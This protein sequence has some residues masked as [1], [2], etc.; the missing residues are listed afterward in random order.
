VEIKMTKIDIKDHSGKI[1]FTHECEGN[2][3]KTTL[4]T[5]IR[6]GISLIGS[7]LGK[8]NLSGADLS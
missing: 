6:L 4:E 8:A 5:A 1:L 3:I 2:T 7:D